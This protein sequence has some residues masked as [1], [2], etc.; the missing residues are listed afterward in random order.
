MVSSYLSWYIWRE[1]NY[2]SFEDSEKTMVN[3]KSFFFNTFY[4][5]AVTLDF[6]NFLRFHDFSLSN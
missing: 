5:W 2:R 3:L 6:L 4:H 1:I